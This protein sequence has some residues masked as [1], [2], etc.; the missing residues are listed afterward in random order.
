MAQQ[1]KSHQR[2]DDYSEVKECTECEHWWTNACDGTK[3]TER[4]CTGFLACR[5]VSIPEDIKALQRALERQEQRVTDLCHI[6]FTLFVGIVAIAISWW[7][8]YG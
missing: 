4:P 6:V 3:G 7:V 5:R 8:C 2:F 1:T